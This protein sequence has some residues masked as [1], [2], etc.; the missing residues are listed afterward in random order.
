MFLYVKFMLTYNEITS[1]VQSFGRNA[2]IFLAERVIEY[3]D[4]N[5]AKFF[6]DVCSTIKFDS[7]CYHFV[8]MYKY[9]RI[10][11]CGMYTPFDKG[12][13]QKYECHL[14]RKILCQII[15][16][17]YHEKLIN[18]MSIFE[19]Y[20]AL[21]TFRQRVENDYQL[22]ILDFSDYYHTIIFEA[23]NDNELLIERTEEMKFRH[24][25]YGCMLSLAFNYPGDVVSVCKN[26]CVIN[27]NRTAIPFQRPCA[28][29]KNPVVFVKLI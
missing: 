14:R 4:I 21:T 6:I 24:E 18:L 19:K 5:V 27:T 11:M 10:V 28:I 25:L 2:I 7:R 15:K 1:F 16:M 20:N 9:I 3:N 13:I 26:G 22:S 8:R 12:H 29:C 17:M 23:P